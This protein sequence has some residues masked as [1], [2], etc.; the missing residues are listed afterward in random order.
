LLTFRY[1]DPAQQIKEKRMTIATDA[2]QAKRQVDDHYKKV[3]K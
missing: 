2:Q 1:K 3:A